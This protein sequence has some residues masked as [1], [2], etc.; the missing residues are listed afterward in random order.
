MILRKFAGRRWVRDRGK[1]LRIPAPGV[2]SRDS[3]YFRNKAIAAP[4]QRLDIARTLGVIFQ[5]L[6]YFSDRCVNAVIGVEKNVFAPDSLD[7]LL[8]GDQLAP[9]FHQ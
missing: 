2:A 6:P 5:N 8:P 7:D 3:P 4:D 9:F 1:G